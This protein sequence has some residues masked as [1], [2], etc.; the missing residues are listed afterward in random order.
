MSDIIQICVPLVI[1]PLMAV[2]RRRVCTPP[3]EVGRSKCESGK[4]IA[5]RALSS[6]R[7]I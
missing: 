1:G 7:H 3:S 5:E 6:T 4:R 2:V